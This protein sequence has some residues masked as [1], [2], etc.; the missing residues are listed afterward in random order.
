MRNII[1][2]LIVLIP[3]SNCI[4]AHILSGDIGYECLGNDDYRVTIALERDCNSNG[5]AF[6]EIIDVAVYSDG[7]LLNNFGVQRGPI[8]DVAAEDYEN[9]MS[10]AFNLC[11]EETTYI[12][13]INLP[14]IDDSYTI[15]YQRCCWSNIIGNILDPGETGITITTDITPLAQAVCNTQEMGS[16]PISFM[17]CPNTDVSIPLPTVDSEGDS[18]VYEICL[19]YSGGGFD[20]AS[21][22]AN[23][24]GCTDVRPIPACPPPYTELEYVSGF[25]HSNPFP[26]VDGFN[27]SDDMLQFTPSTLGYYLAGMCIVE[28]RDGELLSKKQI[29]LSVVTSNAMLSS[30]QNVTMDNWSITNL[31]TSN[32]TLKSSTDSQTTS[33]SIMAISGRN[34]SI[35]KNSD[36][37]IFQADIGHLASG[38][39]AIRIQEENTSQLIRFFKP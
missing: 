16:L 15:A 9:C 7:V 34:V 32:L 11:R 17:S 14:K 19:P 37:N 39:Y 23:G 30:T 21:T 25:D 3:F 13:Q 22:G 18:L 12:F 29:P 33:F 38:V 1:C 26:T 31:T 28:Y 4:A 2:L 10:S 5:A 36:G 27:V 8:L 20:D 35:S 24:N 6:D